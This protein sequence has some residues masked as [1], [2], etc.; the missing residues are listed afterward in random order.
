MRE[1][2]R[3]GLGWKPCDSAGVRDLI[4]RCRSIMCISS[5]VNVKYYYCITLSVNGESIHS[6]N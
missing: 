6:V 2:Q 4:A 1:W 5:E 3:I